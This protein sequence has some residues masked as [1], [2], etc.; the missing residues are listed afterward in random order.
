MA[1]VYIADVSNARLFIVMLNTCTT[2]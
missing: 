1:F 2:V